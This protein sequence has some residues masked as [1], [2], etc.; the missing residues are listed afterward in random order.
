MQYACARSLSSSVVA[1]GLLIIQSSMSVRRKKHLLP[2]GFEKGIW[3]LCVN[4][5]SALLVSPVY[6]A[7]SSKVK[8]SFW[9]MGV[10]LLSASATAAAICAISFFVIGAVRVWL[11]LADC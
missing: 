8:N 2:L 7:A 11:L 1:T 3:R 6:C 4:L 5:Y 9:C 10:I